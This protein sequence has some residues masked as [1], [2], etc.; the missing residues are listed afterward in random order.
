M[1]EIKNKSGVINI[2]KYYSGKYDR[3]DRLCEWAI[4]LKLSHSYKN[5]STVT[6]LHWVNFQRIYFKQ[7]SKVTISFIRKEIYNSCTVLPFTQILGCYQ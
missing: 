7:D 3:M 2:G 4:F 1:N 6:A 5:G